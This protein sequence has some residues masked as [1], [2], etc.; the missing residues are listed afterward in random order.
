[1]A[2]WQP[3]DTI[4]G[5]KWRTEMFLSYAGNVQVSMTVTFKFR[6][7]IPGR[8]SFT[9]RFG[10]EP[11]P[12]TSIA[13]W[14]EWDNGGHGYMLGLVRVRCRCGSLTI[15]SRESSKQGRVTTHNMPLEYA[16]QFRGRFPDPGPWK[17]PRSVQARLTEPLGMAELPAQRVRNSKRRPYSL[18]I[19]VVGES[20]L[21]K[22][23]FMN[24]LFNAPLTEELGPRNL[25]STKTVSID[26]TTYELTEEGVTLQLTVIDTPGFGDQLN[27]ETNF[28][29]IV[30]YIDEQYERYLQAESSQEMRKN[31][32]DSR[33]HA[34]L[35]FLTPSGD[36]RLKDLDVEFLQRLC[37]RVNVIPVI[38][39]ADTLTPEETSAFKKAIIRDFEKYGIHIYPTAHAEDRENIV[40]L[41]RYM[42]FA[43]IGS[44]DL[45]EVNGQRVRG[46]KYRWGSV[47]VENEKHSDFVHLRE[48]LIRTNLQD[49]IET[50]HGVH[51]ATHRGSKIRASGRPES[52]LAS[53]DYYESRVETAKRAMAEDMQRKEDE[54]RQVFVSKVREKEASLREREEQ[55][56]LKRAQMADELE[57]MKR[58]LEI[59]EN[60]YQELVK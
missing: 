33:V 57:K 8:T 48:L 42:P 49:L 41:E 5:P 19:M 44:D 51:Y 4:I 20:G 29:P 1:M 39:R 34:L 14:R 59:E 12:S 17:L 36:N 13:G 32:R 26:P 3:M 10:E 6:S 37:T 40:M 45:V 30:E 46:R 50:T 25:S 24:T 55:L 23:T 60:N 15:S 11:F 27:R 16:H 9:T 31:I 7:L 56:A 58:Q 47:E 28:D 22:T 54:M 52:F 21:G 18:N 2:V 35:Y 53:D 43:V 38:A